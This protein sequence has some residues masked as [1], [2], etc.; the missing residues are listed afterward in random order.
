MY[1]HCVSPVDGF[2]CVFGVVLRVLYRA[3]LYIET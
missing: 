2:V 3:Q 1:L